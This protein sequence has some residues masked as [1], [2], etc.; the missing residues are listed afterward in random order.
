MTDLLFGTRAPTVITRLQNRSRR[1]PKLVTTV[2][3]LRRL[4]DT[5]NGYIV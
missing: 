1:R 3:N 2:A 5:G 4:Y